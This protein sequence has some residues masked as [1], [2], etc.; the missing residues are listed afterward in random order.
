MRFGKRHSVL[1]NCFA[2]LYIGHESLSWTTLPLLYFKKFIDLLNLKHLRLISI[3]QQ[4]FLYRI[5][6]TEGT[7]LVGELDERFSRKSRTRKEFDP[8]DF[9]FAPETLAI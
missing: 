5:L 7:V 3:S 1:L 4:H 6:Y 9:S 2:G 8:F